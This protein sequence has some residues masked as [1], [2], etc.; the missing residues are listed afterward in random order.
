MK[1]YTVHIIWLVVAIV[2]LGGGY[3]WGKAGAAA[4]RG[5]GRFAGAGTFGSSTR[6]FAGGAAGGGFTTGQIMEVDSSSIT[7]QLPTGN[8]EIVFY[9]TSTPVT[10]PTVVSVSKLAVGTNVMVVGTSNS[11]GSLTAQSIQ[12]RPGNPNAA[13]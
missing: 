2:A 11:D 10:E 9:S 8:S 12:V 7:L 6:S 3:Y 4:T 13:Q 5:A 1:K